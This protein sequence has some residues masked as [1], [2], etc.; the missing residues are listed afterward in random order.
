MADPAN[1]QT[2]CWLRTI[3][4]GAEL[5]N[6]ATLAPIPS[7]TSM[8]GNAQQTSVPADA[9][10]V[11]QVAPVSIPGVPG[12]VVVCLIRFILLSGVE[13]IPTIY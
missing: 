1:T 5:V 11:T 2:L 12:S 3:R 6:A 13:Y 10:N 8:M 4:N 9:N 7:V